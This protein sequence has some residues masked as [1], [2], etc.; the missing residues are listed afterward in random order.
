MD[1]RKG[2]SVAG[3]VDAEQ[4]CSNVDEDRVSRADGRGATDQELLDMFR[5]VQKLPEDKKRSV[6][7]FL[8]AYLFRE[9]VRED[10]TCP[11]FPYSFKC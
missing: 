8:E 4:G 10:M 5:Q 2:P 1:V 6:K 9:R 11:L 3:A 7:D